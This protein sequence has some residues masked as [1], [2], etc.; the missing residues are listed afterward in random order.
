MLLR[1]ATLAKDSTSRDP[2]SQT[3]SHS[4]YAGQITLEYL[5]VI[6]RFAGRLPWNKGPF[7]FKFGAEYPLYRE[8]NYAWGAEDPSITFD[9]TWTNGPLDSSPGSPIG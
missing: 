3:R 4:I 9:S 8:N 1:F 6:E 5:W 2:I 7:S